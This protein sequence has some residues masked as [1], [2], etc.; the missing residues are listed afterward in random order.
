MVEAR[1]IHW[2]E[3][4]RIDA[5][6][7]DYISLINDRFQNNQYKSDYL[8]NIFRFIRMKAKQDR[9]YIKESRAYL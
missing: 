8:K 5:I 7:S 2:T 1:K 9:H 6:N 3:L 4:S